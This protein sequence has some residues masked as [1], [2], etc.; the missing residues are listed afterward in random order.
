[1]RFLLVP[2]LAWNIWLLAF[3][4]INFHLAPAVLGDAFRQY[5]LGTSFSL[6]VL[7]KNWAS[8]GLAGSGLAG[9]V[10]VAWLAGGAAAGLASRALRSD[11]L[12]RLGVGFGLLGTGILGL[13]LAGLLFA[14][15]AAA[16][17]VALA[18]LWVWILLRNR[19]G[20]RLPALTL[21]PLS[22]PVTV[23]AG[24]AAVVAVA[25]ILNIEISWDALSYHLRLPSFYVYRHKFYDVWHHFCAPFPSQ[26]E[27]LYAVSFV[28]QE[29]YLARFLNALFCILLL[30]ALMSLGRAAGLEARWAP[31]LLA[32]SPL[33]PALLTRAYIDPGLAF[34]LTLS[35]ILF[36]RWW[37][38]AGGGALVISGVLAGWGLSCKYTGAFFLAGIL[39][40]ALPRLGKREG[41]NAAALWCSAA[42]LPFLPWLLKNWLFRGNPLWPYL[43]AI[44]GAHSVIPPDVTPFFEKASPLAGLA[45]LLPRRAGGLFFDNGRVDGPLLPAVWGLLPLLA[46]PPSSDAMAVLRRSVFGYLAAWFLLAPDVRFLLPAL[47]AL[48]LTIEP[49]I[50]SVAAA[51][52][53]A[54][55]WTRAI[56]ETG[57]ASGMLY[58]ACIQWTFF[59]P[60]T[61]PLGR[62]DPHRKLEMGLDP[63][64]WAAYTKDFVNANL[65]RNARIMF[66]SHFSTYYYERECIADF[67][68]GTSHLAEILRENRTAEDMDKRLR[69]LGIR[70]LLD[71]WTGPNQYGKI[72]GYYDVP[73]GVPEQFKRFIAERGEAVWLMDNF[74]LFRLGRRHAARPLPSLPVYGWLPL[75]GAEQA[76]D[77][78]QML[79]ALASLKS[80]P[81]LARNLGTTWLQRGDIQNGL[82]DFAGAESSFRHALEYGL[83]VPRVRLG[84]SYALL[85]LGR[86]RAALPHA[87]EAF[88]RSPLSAYAAANLASIE[89]TLG[90]RTRALELVREAVRR[91]PGNEAYRAMARQFEDGSGRPG[92][93][94]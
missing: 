26:V 40:A 44:F 20:L 55:K 66:L 51:G 77:T 82:E 23:V 13:G 25:G 74:T 65:P 85:R 60:F 53:A 22:P 9:M 16:M 61:L 57:L 42:L 34:F 64:P 63:P 58:G 1:M 62:E 89:A 70:W 41:R 10:S 21:P 11:Y 32:G 47:P 78:G 72:P 91:N 2:L 31:L 75:A 43:G 92:K 73:P 7:L 36:V 6:P 67:H 79:R 5:F 87:T 49:A 38:G 76:D 88:R 17:H 37:R 4:I 45:Y 80:P 39:A 90:N 19:S 52:A 50:A 86:P 56:L 12:I 14:P 84:L 94:R 93:E 46:M 28:I 33:F 81:P 83:D 71:I 48:V 27:M 29:E 15:P 35:L 54:R 69:Q 68:Y 24:L 8:F 3:W 59:A 18:A 30:P